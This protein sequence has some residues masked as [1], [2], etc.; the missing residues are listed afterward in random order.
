MN[1]SIRILASVGVLG[2]SQFCAVVHGK[3]V[4]LKLDTGDVLEFRGHHESAGQ[5][6]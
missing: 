2:L 1:K 6:R 4:D 5:S 3:P